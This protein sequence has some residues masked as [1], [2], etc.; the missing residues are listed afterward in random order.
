MHAY[1]EQNIADQALELLCATNNWLLA[2]QQWL[3][4]NMR[5]IL[6]GETPPPLNKLQ[7]FDY[8]IPNDMTLS[9]HLTKTFTKISASLESHWQHTTASIHPMSGLTVFEQ[10]NSYQSSAH[11]FMVA[12]KQANQT[13]LEKFAMLDSLTGAQTRLTMNANLAQALT[14]A[15]NSD[16]SAC[17]ALLDQDNFKQINDRWGHVTGDTVLAKTADIIHENL[18]VT[19]KLFRLGGDEWLILM[20]KTSRGLAKKILAR[21]Q[22]IYNAYEFRSNDNHAFSSTFSYGIAESNHDSTVKDWLTHADHQLYQNKQSA[23]H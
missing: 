3:L 8:V 1:H 17:I 7:P 16:K 18:R 19:D 6:T 4:D 5:C 15:Q 12:A 23:N 21:I 13:L 20:P 11:Q 14:L 9:D 2:R 10:L 22:N